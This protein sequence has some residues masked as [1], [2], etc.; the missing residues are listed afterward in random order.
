MNNFGSSI[1]N[2]SYQ[3][4]SNPEVVN[5][6]VDEFWMHVERNTRNT[7]EDYAGSFSQTNPGIV[8]TRYNVAQ[9]PKND[10]TFDFDGDSSFPS[11][12]C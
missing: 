7:T 4:L 1:E 3:L 5:Q 8:S 11:H 9:V 10:F 6:T 2:Q 12:F